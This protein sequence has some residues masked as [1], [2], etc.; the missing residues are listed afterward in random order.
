MVEIF[1]EAG[2]DDAC[3]GVMV[4]P[5][6]EQSSLVGCIIF[7]IYTQ[8]GSGYLCFHRYIQ[9][10]KSNKGEHTKTETEQIKF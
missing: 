8:P 9:I 5:G 2:S 1:R 3:M 7:F 6:L 10:K 4:R